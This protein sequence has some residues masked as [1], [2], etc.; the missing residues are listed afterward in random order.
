MPV[1]LTRSEDT[2][3]GD[4]ERATLGSALDGGVCITLHATATGTGVHI[5]YPM[6][7]FG[8]P[9]HSFL[10]QWS[11]TDVPPS[12]QSQP[13]AHSL[14]AALG[15]AQ[16]SATL[17]PAA[18]P[19]ISRERCAAVAIELAP[20]RQEGAASVTAADAQYQQRVAAA[21][22]QAIADWRDQRRSLDASA[23][24]YAKRFRR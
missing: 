19:V 7:Q 14:Q 8:L 24:A 3:V 10:D 17:E 13:L 23:A 11:A 21:I 20:I 12:T 22:A 16:V 1:R 5:F 4:N 2:T 15:K 18:G 6:P 9:N